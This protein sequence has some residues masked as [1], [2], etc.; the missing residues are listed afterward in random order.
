M[1]IFYMLRFLQDGWMLT[2]EVLPPRAPLLPTLPSQH[3]THP[4]LTVPTMAAA[5]CHLLR[6]C[7][8]CWTLQPHHECIRRRAQSFLLILINSR[9]DPDFGKYILLY[10]LSSQ[11]GVCKACAK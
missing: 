3:D 11:G 7:Q 5:I 1:H 2:N 6:G 10:V 4:Q 8:L 9:R